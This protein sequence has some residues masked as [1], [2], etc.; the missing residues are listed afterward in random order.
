MKAFVISLLLST[1]SN[2]ILCQLQ[3]FGD[4]DFKVA[5]SIALTLF[6]EDL[7]NLPVLS[8]QLTS[9][10]STDVEKFR[11]IYSWVCLNII[12][13]VDAYQLNKVKREKLAD[14]QMSLNEWNEKFRKRMFKNLLEKQS[15]VC[16]GY[17]YLISE[18][19]SLSG[20]RCEIVNGYGRTAAVSLSNNA[21]PNHSWNAV[22]I[23]GKWYLCDATWSSGGLL[24]EESIFLKDYNDG[25][26]LAEPDLFAYS[27]YPIDT[28]WLKTNSKTSFDTFLSK[29]LVYK[30]AFS[31]QIKP[32]EPAKMNVDL[33][34]NESLDFVVH[35]EKEN[36]AAKLSLSIVQGNWTKDVNLNILSQTDGIYEF[37]YTFNRKGTYDV[38]LKVDDDY[39]ATYSVRVKN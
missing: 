15:T 35:I 21:I 23:H 2:P 1:I 34:R 18:L 25:Y 4:I 10:L 30:Y 22:E 8:Y 6:G 31:Y 36:I 33:K 3:D 28:F 38:H 20:L 7:T 5:D 19:A 16:T 26:F 17:A 11:A 39:V 13:D 14:K 29:P 24:I 12:N 37:D 9:A 32:I 27:H